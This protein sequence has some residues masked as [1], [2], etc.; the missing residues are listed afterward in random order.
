LCRRRRPETV[1]RRLVRPL[2]SIGVPA[3]VIHGT[4]D[5]MFP[6]EHGRALAGAI[7]G[8]RL[9]ALQGAGHGIERA[10]WEA[11]AAAIIEHTVGNSG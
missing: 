3:L 1:E 4:G 5:P 10:D 8:A 6:I 7:P 9:L 2:S 11:I